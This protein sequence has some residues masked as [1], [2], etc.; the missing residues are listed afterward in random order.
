MER[1]MEDTAPLQQI[2]TRCGPSPYRP[3]RGPARALTI[4]LVL[5]TVITAIGG[6]SDWLAFTRILGNTS[7]ASAEWPRQRMIAS[8]QGLT[9]LATVTGFLVWSTAH[10]RTCTRSGW[11]RCGSGLD[12]PS[13]DGSCRSSTSSAPS[14]S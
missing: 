9:Y 4:L 10:T 13:A 8:L 7:T 1:T 3:L 11:S 5:V 14:S 12:G 2:P 6:V